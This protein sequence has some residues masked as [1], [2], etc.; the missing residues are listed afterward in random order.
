MCGAGHQVLA[1]TPILEAFGNAKTARNH[2]S[3]RFGNLCEVQFD[4]SGFLVGASLKYARGRGSAEREG[5]VEGVTSHQPPVYSQNI[6]ISSCTFRPQTIF[7]L[8]SGIRAIAFPPRFCEN[9]VKK[10]CL[11]TRLLFVTSDCGDCP[12]A[13]TICSRRRV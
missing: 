3:S 13:G 7:F 1:A 12:S 5:A 9:N 10:P 4:E 2:N 6:F 8:G 11:S